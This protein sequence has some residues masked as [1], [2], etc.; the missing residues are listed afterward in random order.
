MPNTWKRRIYFLWF[1]KNHIVRTLYSFLNLHRTF[2]L[3]NENILKVGTLIADTL[4]RTNVQVAGCSN[5]NKT[6]QAFTSFLSASCSMW[7]ILL[8]N[9]HAPSLLLLKIIFFLG[10]DCPVQIQIFPLFTPNF[11][12]YFS[13]DM[14]HYVFHFI[15][16]FLSIIDFI[17]DYEFLN[18]WICNLSFC[19]PPL[20][21]TW[22]ISFLELP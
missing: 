17:L 21:H 6:K 7:N 18:G 9:L 12:F 19:L 16:Y 20:L 22:H 11:S 1:I 14:K 15:F 13:F 5:K 2:E 10:L 8:T 3:L 4:V